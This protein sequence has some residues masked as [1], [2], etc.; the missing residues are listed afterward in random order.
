[1]QTLS[2]YIKQ[3]EKEKIAIGH[4]NF[5]NL[6]MFNAV[7]ESAKELN[8]P[9]I[10]GVSER[11]RDFVGIRNAVALVRAAREQGGVPI[12]LNADH[13]YSFER[14]KEA[15]D[16]GFDAVIFD[17]VKLSPE[18]N[19]EITKKCVD[20][21][22]EIGEKENREILVEAELGYIGG[23]S[24]ILDEIPEGAGVIKTSP[25]EAKKF[26]KETGIDLLAPSVGN[27][28]GLLKGGNPDLDI[29]LILRI[30]KEAGVP[31]VLHGGSGITDEEFQ[32]AIEAGISVVHISTEMRKAYREGIEKSLEVGDVIAPYAYLDLPK[33]EVKRV[34]LGRLKLFSKI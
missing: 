8:V 18:E 6:E 12:F 30:R 13:T 21:A 16:L 22:C 27:I 4:F 31:L 11:E 28:H 19:I 20:Y 14:V 1:M 26:V 29:D 33:K 24:K 9:V 32:K 17:G 15:I 25:E 2:E 7:V 5:S 3:A 10:A 34:V 23:S